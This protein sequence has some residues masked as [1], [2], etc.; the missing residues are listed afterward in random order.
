[1]LVQGD[2]GLLAEQAL[3]AFALRIA[4]AEIV[5]RDAADL[6]GVAE[7]AVVLAGFQIV[8]RGVAG[9]PASLFEH[10]CAP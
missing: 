3:G 8:V 9:V 6:L 10:G 5:S 2:H 4:Q 7:F 1:M